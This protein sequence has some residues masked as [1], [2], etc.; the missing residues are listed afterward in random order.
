[1]DVRSAELTKNAANALLA[2][3]ISLMN[4]LAN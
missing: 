3:K 1:M 4:E 2:A